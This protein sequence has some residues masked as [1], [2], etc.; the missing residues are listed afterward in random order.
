MARWS[1][2]RASRRTSSWRSR[3]FMAENP[4]NLLKPAA[5]GAPSHA[6]ENRISLIQN[7]TMNRRVATIISA[8]RRPR[9]AWSSQALARQ[10]REVA[11]TDKNTPDDNNPIARRNF[12][13]GASTAVAAGL[14]PTAAAQAQQPAAAAAADATGSE[15]ATRLTLTRGGAGVLAAR[16][17]QVGP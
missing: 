15:P 12:L 14:A 8:R 4:R 13:L 6:A 5:V 2:A 1:A 9:P 16:G 10:A 11:M 7:D 3:A 17:G